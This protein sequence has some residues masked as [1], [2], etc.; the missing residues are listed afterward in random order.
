[1]RIGTFAKKNDISV[2]TIRYYMELGLIVPVKKGGQYNFTNTCQKSLDQVLS[3]KQMGF[4]LNEIKN[5]FHFSA[6]SRIHSL[7]EKNHYKQYFE[8]NYTR[9]KQE[10][11]RLE[12]AKELVEKTLYNMDISEAESKSVIGLPIQVLDLLSCPKCKND[13][14]FKEGI[15]E[16]NKIIKGCLSCQ[17]GQ[18]YPIEKGILKIDPVYEDLNYPD[19]KDM[20]VEYFESTASGY[21]EKIYIA[22]KWMASVAEGWTKPEV[23]LEPGVGSGYA[24][25]QTLDYIPKGA[26]YIAVD[27]NMNRLIKMRE[28][29]SKSDIHFNLVLVACDFLK[30]P[31]KEKSVDVVMDMSGSSNRAFDSPDFLLKEICPVF[32]KTARLYGLYIM[33][34]GI[35][36]REIPQTHHYLFQKEPIKEAIQNLGFDIKYE[37][38]TDKTSEG[39][40]HE[41]YVDVVKST[42]TYCFYA[43]R[44]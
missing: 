36:G 11:K 18:I 23:I 10:I 30:I 27:H 40:P 1:M 5:I 42:W 32:K 35:D 39:G 44:E 34:D 20:R 3:F 16:D 26:T 7:E 24:L 33:A 14:F 2:E 29:F 37:T 8:E 12:S 41:S 17:C 21:I 13:L 31:L 9:I 6:L 19:E 38:E 25:G 15:V 22:G 4:T 43:I 28:Y